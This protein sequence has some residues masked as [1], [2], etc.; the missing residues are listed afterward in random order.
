VCNAMRNHFFSSKTGHLPITYASRPDKILALIGTELYN[1]HSIQTDCY[2][3]GH[4]T[5]RLHASHPTCTQQ[6]PNR[7]L[8]DTQQTPNRHS[9]DTQQ[10]PY[11]HPTDTRRTPS[12]PKVTQYTLK[13]HRIATQQSPNDR[14][15]STR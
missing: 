15:T 8:T 12:N 6:T 3:R 1:S 14:S 11:G 7:H 4:S 10:T 9:T 5:S 2:L 13:R